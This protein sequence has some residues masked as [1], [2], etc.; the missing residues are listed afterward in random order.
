MKQPKTSKPL[1]SSEP[2]ESTKLS[3]SMKRPRL[4][5][6][7]KSTKPA[8][9]LFTK[10]NLVRLTYDI[11]AVLA[12][13]LVAVAGLI[14]L[15]LLMT[16]VFGQAGSLNRFLDQAGNPL[17]NAGYHPDISM[18]V[19][20]NIINQFYSWVIVALGI[21][22]VVGAALLVWT[23]LRWL[24]RLGNLMLSLGAS[25]MDSQPEKASL[26][27]ILTIW[28]MTIV[29]A[30]AVLNITATLHYLLTLCGVM[31]VNLLLA[32]IVNMLHERLVEKD[33]S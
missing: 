16:L 17:A 12:K 20:M 32:G 19:R 13:S 3:E 14:G 4:V 15:F 8:D 27:I 11:L 6:S 23:L 5:K 18:E 24:S 33:E 2:T 30:W 25:L 7:T 22:I 29:L 28:S 9:R 10:D 26:F 31:L 1:K 21:L